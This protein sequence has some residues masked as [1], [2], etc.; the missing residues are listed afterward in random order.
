[1]T[2]AVLVNSAAGSGRQAGRIPAVLDALAAELPT[3]L[4]TATDAGQAR[5]AV[6]EAIDQGVEGL[7]VVGGDGSLHNVL[8]VTAGRGVPVAVVPTGTCNDLADSLGLPADPVDAA[9][10]VARAFAAGNLRSMDVARV[11]YPD[12]TRTWYATVLAAG[13]AASVSQRGGRLRWPR[14]MRRYDLAAV[15][16]LPRFRGRV[17]TVTLD[18]VPAT[19]PAVLF[20]VGNTRRFG[21]K[22]YVCPDAEIDDGLLDVTTQGP[23]SVPATLGTTLR[24]FNGVRSATDTSTRRFGVRRIEMRDAGLVTFAD[25]EALGPPPFTVTCVAGA[26]SVPKVGEHG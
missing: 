13:Y 18:G 23:N 12:G 6:A 11:D 8:Q 1:M 9:R 5:R 16:E 2:V 15:L 20:A 7:V 14:G 22:L 3:R 10:A 21:G 17:Y 25:G 4:L 24:L 19:L 26:L